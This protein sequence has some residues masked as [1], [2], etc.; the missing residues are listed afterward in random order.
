[1]VEH[2]TRTLPQSVRLDPGMALTPN[3]MRTLK[4]VT[5]RTLNDLLGGDAE[6]MD[7][8]P[9]RL[10]ALVWIQLRRDGV[11]ASWEEAGDILPDLSGVVPDPTSNGL[12]SSSSASAASGG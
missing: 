9:D 1:M 10:Q 4:D 12:S 7:A 3:E 8:A 6:D 11:D 5:G 2:L